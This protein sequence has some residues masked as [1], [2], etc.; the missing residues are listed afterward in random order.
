LRA[1]EGAAGNRTSPSLVTVKP[2]IAPRKP[3][4]SVAELAVGEDFEPL[5]TPAEVAKRLNVNRE[6]VY[7]MRKRGELPFVRVG[8]AIRVRPEALEAFL[9]RWTP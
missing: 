1:L 8:A 4:R 5:L 7:R 9:Q 2:S 6:T 3:P